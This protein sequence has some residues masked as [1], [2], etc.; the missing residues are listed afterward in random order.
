MT[1]VRKE[2][3]IFLL[4]VSPALL[5]L[6]IFFIWPLFSSFWISFHTWPMFGKPKWVGLDNYIYTLNDSRFW[7][8]LKFTTIYTFTATPMLFIVALITALLCNVK[9][10]GT[11]FFRAMYF[12]LVVLSFAT[13]SYIWLWLYS[14]LYGVIIYFLELFGFGGPDKNLNVWTTTTSG[15]WAVNTMVTWK[16]SGIQMIF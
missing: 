14:E 13:A 15:L 2:R 9:T 4:M 1:Y 7:D 12:L 8:T 6:A 5:L 10:W 3:I 16:F 11:T